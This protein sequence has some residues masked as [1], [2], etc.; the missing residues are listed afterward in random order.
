MSTVKE[1]DEEI[2]REW[3]A[4]RAERP[5]SV[6][7]NRFAFYGTLRGGQYNFNRFIKDS[8]KT[9]EGK[10]VLKG[11]KMF[12]FGAFP[13]VV[14]TGNEEDV[15]VVELYEVPDELV[16]R[17]INM[18]ELGAGYGVEEVTINDKV[19]W[20]YVYPNNWEYSK[21]GYPEIP[22][23]DWVEYKQAEAKANA[24]KLLEDG[25]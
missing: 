11:Y 10:E 21:R 7:H 8:G 6:V 18:M 9:F 20:L 5:L 22:G 13:F 15:I 3:A 17:S 4:K 19:Y 16:C 12:S 25:W 24:E 23:G 2:V 1:K 14:P